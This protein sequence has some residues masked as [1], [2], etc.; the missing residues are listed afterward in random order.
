MWEILSYLQG[1]YQHWSPLFLLSEGHRIP[2]PR[3][4]CR[5]VILI[6]LPP[7]SAL[8]KNGWNLCLFPL[9][10][11]VAWKVARSLS[12]D[13]YCDGKRIILLLLYFSR[14]LIFLAKYCADFC[15]VVM[16][17]PLTILV[18]LDVSILRI[19]QGVLIQWRINS[20]VSAACF[21]HLNTPCD[22]L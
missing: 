22:S 15:Y 17:Y 5:C 14:R 4:K 8:L 10:N 9:C 3:T 20:T 7:H 13:L 19:I 18:T 21:R 2:F 11:F 1:P 12:C 6:L 16:V